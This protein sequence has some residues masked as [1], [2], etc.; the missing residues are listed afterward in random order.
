MIQRIQSVYLFLASLSVFGQ[1]GLPYASGTPTEASA[2]ADGQINLFDN[3][4]LLGLTVLGG[5]TSIIAIFLFK[6]RGLQ[7]RIAGAA[8][9][10][11]LLLIVLAAFICKQSYDASN[12]ALHFGAGLALP[13]LS[14]VLNWLASRAIRKD[15]K[16]VKS[17]DRLR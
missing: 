5:L 6:N 9:F 12:G 1:F 8:V 16:L 15:D 3:I 7:M 14:V 13:V 17:M 2:L 4:G 11:S 10:V